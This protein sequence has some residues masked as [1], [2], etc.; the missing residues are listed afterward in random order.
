M[1]KLQNLLE[2]ATEMLTN[3]LNPLK[4]RVYHESHLLFN[5]KSLSILFVECVYG[6]YMILENRRSF[7]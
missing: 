7:S 4:E 1:K 3:Q 6:F 2:T 5:I